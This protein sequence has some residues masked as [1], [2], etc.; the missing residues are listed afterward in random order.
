MTIERDIDKEYTEYLLLDAMSRLNI[1]KEILEDKSLIA[2][3]RCM[4]IS[5]IV[6]GVK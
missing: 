2:E 3:D 6:R 5:I 4:K 1:I